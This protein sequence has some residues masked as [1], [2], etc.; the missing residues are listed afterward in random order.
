MTGR[1]RVITLHV[2]G[3]SML[4]KGWKAGDVCRG[5]GIKAS[6]STPRKGFM[7]HTKHLPDV[8]AYLEHNHITAKVVGKGIIQ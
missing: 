2:E 1:R 8:V 7:A 3:P 5:V 4:V 6:W